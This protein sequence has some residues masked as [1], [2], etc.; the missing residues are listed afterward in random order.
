MSNRPLSAF[1]DGRA[2]EQEPARELWERF[3]S[4]MDSHRNDFVGFARSEGFAHAEV[5]VI[6]GVP[7]LKL[8]TNAP[9]KPKAG[10]GRGKRRRPRRN[11]GR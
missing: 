5:T 2:L 3:S 7:T 4:Y 8:A 11:G 10:G 6:N 9:K 1:V